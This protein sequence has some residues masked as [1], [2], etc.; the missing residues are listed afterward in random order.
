MLAVF[1]NNIFNS[2]FADFFLG[3]LRIEFW[4]LLT[5]CMGQQSNPHFDIV[6][7]CYLILF[8]SLISPISFISLIPFSFSLVSLIPL[9]TPSKS[10]RASA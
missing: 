5:M 6:L 7:K 2:C 9:P 8:I 10:P 3:S 1:R 4:R